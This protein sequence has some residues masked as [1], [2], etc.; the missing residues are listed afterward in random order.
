MIKYIRNHAVAAPAADVEYTNL[1]EFQIKNLL[2]GTHQCK[3]FLHFANT[4][5]IQ[6]VIFSRNRLCAKSPA[7]KTISKTR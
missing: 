3:F 1:T 6:A 4:Y 2:Q 7:I 5:K